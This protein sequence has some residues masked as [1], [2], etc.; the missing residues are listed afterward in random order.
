M[1]CDRDLFRFH[2]PNK[3]GNLMTSANSQKRPTW[4]ESRLTCST[5]SIAAI[6]V[7]ASTVAANSGWL[8]RL[9]AA[10]G[11]TTTGSP[12]AISVSI[13]GGSDITGGAFTLATGTGPRNGSVFEFQVGVG[14]GS[15]ASPYVNEGDI[16]T[17]TP[18]GG[19]GSNIPGAFGAVIRAI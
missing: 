16:I 14:V 11:G 15:N 4:N 1:D 9:T 10:C 17:F 18:S 5:L 2:K 19:T 8:T 6:P 13:N 7:A 3:L 12:I